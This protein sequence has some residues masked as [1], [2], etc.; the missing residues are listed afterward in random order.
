MLIRNIFRFMI[1]IMLAVFLEYMITYESKGAY[2]NYEVRKMD[3]KKF[4]SSSYENIGYSEEG[5]NIHNYG[6][7]AIM[8]DC[9]VALKSMSIN[10]SCKDVIKGRVLLKDE[11]TKQY[12]QYGT[13]FCLL[14]GG[15]GEQNNNIFSEKPGESKRCNDSILQ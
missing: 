6:E 8:N 13:E 14:S 11:G 10:V 3:L 5:M 7:V 1:C 2:E 15:G 12:W 9:N 4:Y